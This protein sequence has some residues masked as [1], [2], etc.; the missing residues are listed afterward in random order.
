MAGRQ[1]DRIAGRKT[2]WLA[3]RQGGRQKERMSSKQAG[4]LLGRQDSWQKDR[5]AGKQEFCIVYMYVELRVSVQ[6]STSSKRYIF[7]VYYILNPN[8]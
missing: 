8:N 6:N 4:R 1:E 2:G 5:I 7:N 3:E